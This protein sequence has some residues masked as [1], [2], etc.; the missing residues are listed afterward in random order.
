MAKLMRQTLDIPKIL[1]EC[2]KLGDYRTSRSI[3]AS[4]PSPPATYKLQHLKTSLEYLKSPLPVPEKRRIVE[5]LA[6]MVE[7]IDTP[8][9][10]EAHE[11][12]SQVWKVSQKRP[13]VSLY[14]LESNDTTIDADWAKSLVSGSAY[15]IQDTC[16][17]MMNLAHRQALL[18]LIVVYSHST[19]TLGQDVELEATFVQALD[20]IASYPEVDFVGGDLFQSTSNEISPSLVQFMS[21]AVR[22]ATRNIKF[23]SKQT[24]VH[25]INLAGY[26]DRHD[27]NF[28]PMVFG[29]VQALKSIGEFDTDA[30]LA[31]VRA[32]SQLSNQA[33]GNV[34]LLNIVLNLVH[35]YSLENDVRVWSSVIWSCRELG[36]DGEA[37]KR[38]E[39]VLGAMLQQGVVH[40][41]SSV[42]RLMETF[43]VAGQA[44]HAWEL[45]ED[46][47]NRGYDMCSLYHIM[48][49]GMSGSLSQASFVLEE[50]L[51][52]LERD[53]IRMTPRLMRALFQA[54]EVSQSWD[55]A[56]GL[57]LQAKTLAIGGYEWCKMLQSAHSCFSHAPGGGRGQTHALK[58]TRIAEIQSEI[59]AK[60][61]AIEPDVFS[62]MWAILPPL[63]KA[64][65]SITRSNP[66]ESPH[67]WLRRLRT[68]FGHLKA[69]LDHVQTE[70][71][72]LTELFARWKDANGAWDSIAL[73]VV[74]ESAVK[75]KQREA[76]KLEMNLVRRQINYLEATLRNE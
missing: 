38:L 73:R 68:H 31:V 53:S 62:R 19:L 57:W 76:I 49:E 28:M 63:S 32:A 27:P 23:H 15:T 33:V 47:R 8:E 20:F 40:S 26:L 14:R 37:D 69:D 66:K 56:I 18:P 12:M 64:T 1:A 67:Q 30:K 25:L 11:I 22:N 2:T 5:K 35:E 24:I 42:E 72:D 51:P 50:L 39:V 21:R 16:R 41:Q 10:V 46:S 4:M 6:A 61:E 71:R 36:R 34:P 55:V 60:A 29:V 58:S 65:K 59:N 44:Q 13:E 48:I 74:L 3:L 70:T 9:K 7:S 52:D 75:S 43:L 54:C 17:Y 45:L